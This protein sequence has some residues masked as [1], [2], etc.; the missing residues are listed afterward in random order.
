[1][2]RGDWPLPWPRGKERYC[3]S[4]AALQALLAGQTEREDMLWV[5]GRAVFA[6][7]ALVVP[8]CT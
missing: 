4:I 6:C 3:V 1:M 8:V 2:S 7:L 5:F